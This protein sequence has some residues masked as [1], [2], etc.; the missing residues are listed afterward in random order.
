MAKMATHE[1]DYILG[2]PCKKRSSINSGAWLQ[3]FD[4]ETRKEKN[5][6]A[7]AIQGKKVKENVSLQLNMHFPQTQNAWKFAMF[8][9]FIHSQLLK[10]V[11]CPRT[12]VK[13]G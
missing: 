4:E 10:L 1:I 3:R 5:C 8:K 13:L 2:V 7:K 9:K 6:F 11:F 12:V